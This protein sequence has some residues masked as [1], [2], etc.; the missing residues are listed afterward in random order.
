MGGVFS[1]P[2]V[3]PP[4]PVPTLEDPA[5]AQARAA[6]AAAER[7]AQ[8]RAATVIT[9]GEGDTSE[10]PLGRKSMLGT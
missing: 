3:P 6:Q 5:I 2:K 1:G 8:G 9:G 10:A 7:K 4:T